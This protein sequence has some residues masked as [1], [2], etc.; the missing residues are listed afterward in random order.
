MTVALPT[1][2]PAWRLVG[3]PRSGGPVKLVKSWLSVE[4]PELC[5]QTVTPTMSASTDA[6]TQV[7]RGTGLS[8]L[9]AFPPS[10]P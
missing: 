8:V 9:I 1:M 5:A 2:T 6:T 10:R 4:V 3:P 7:W